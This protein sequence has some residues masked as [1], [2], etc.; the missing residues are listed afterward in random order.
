L[1]QAAQLNIDFGGAE[2]NAAV[3]LAQ[4]GD[5]V[6]FITRVPDHS[7]AKSALR[8]IEGSGVETRN[9]LLEGNR[10]GLYYYENG[11]IGRSGKVIYDRDGSA[12]AQLQK[13]MV[14]W[15]A[16]LEGADWFHWSGITPAV[17]EGAMDVLL[18]GLEVAKQN[19]LI[20]SMDYNYRGNLWKWGK[21]ADEVMPQ[22]MEYCH[23][24]SG[25]H[26]DVDVLQ[27]EVPDT[28]F[29]EE[30]EKMMA[31]FPN[32]QKVVFTSRGV[33]SASHNTWSGALYNGQKVYRSKQYDLVPIV[34]RVGGGDA[35]MA[36][37]IYGLRRLENL[38]K[39]IDFS[40]AASAIKHTIE[41]DQNYCTVDE[42][43][44]FV[45]SN[46]SGKIIR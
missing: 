26:P 10:I 45:K 46:G 22:L 43:Q 23:V 31:R 39:A 19:G 36:A 1:G 2:A 33:V 34:D 24:M 15:Q 3:S 29:Q 40:I 16:V 11:A 13:G 30:G 7:L 17:S 4:F 12:F 28:L 18:E 8:H 38:Q 21:S 5:S 37:L 20:I 6:E 41:G 9:S 27:G 25:T 35:F 44:D 42:V 32:C 14:D